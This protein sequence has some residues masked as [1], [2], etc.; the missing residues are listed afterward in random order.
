MGNTRKNWRLSF[1][2]DTGNGLAG[3]AR[4]YMIDGEQERAAN[5]PLGPTVV[6]SPSYCYQPQMSVD[7]YAPKKQVPVNGMSKVGARR[8]CRGPHDGNSHKPHFFVSEIAEHVPW[9]TCKVTPGVAETASKICFLTGDPGKTAEGL[10]IHSE[11]LG[12]RWAVPYFPLPVRSPEKGSQNGSWGMY[13]AP[14][15][16]ANMNRKSE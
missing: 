4:V 15:T 11:L 14:R 9:T 6:L 12:L 5:S 10:C 8:S 16:H 3:H 2:R 7:Q 1:S 13:V